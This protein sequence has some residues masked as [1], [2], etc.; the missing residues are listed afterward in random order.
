MPNVVALSNRHLWLMIGNLV[1]THLSGSGL[2]DK[3]GLTHN[4]RV[5]CWVSWKGAGL[6]GSQLGWLDFALHKISCCRSW[7]GFQKRKKGEGCVCGGRWGERHRERKREKRLKAPRSPGSD[8][9]MASSA[10]FR[11]KQEKSPGQSQGVR[12]WVLLL[13]GRNHKT[14]LWRG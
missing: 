3:S 10:F 8:W 14:T 13:D 1:W 4:S 2:I 9:H 12:A 11:L 5:S 7:E 6:G